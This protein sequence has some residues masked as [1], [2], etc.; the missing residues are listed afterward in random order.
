VG[1]IKLAM[2]MFYY[3]YHYLQMYDFV[4]SSVSG[5]FIVIALSIAVLKVHIGFIFLVLVY[6]G[7]HGRRPLNGFTF[8]LSSAQVTVKW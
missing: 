6:P 2:Q 4:M 1:S 3:L 5:V 7:Y 8:A